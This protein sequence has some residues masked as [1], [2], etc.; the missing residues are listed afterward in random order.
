[1]IVIPAPELRHRVFEIF[2]AADCPE[3][4]A[5]QVAHSLVESN[6]V[7]H[8]S[9]GM[10]RVPA[11]VR[12]IRADR[13]H[14]RAEIRVVKESASTALLDCGFIFARWQPRGVWRWLSPRHAR[15]TSRW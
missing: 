5:R 15:L 4:V 12:A 8:D 10:I 13:L 14:P 1:M 9:H 11:Y 3:A 6:L 7:G 2:E